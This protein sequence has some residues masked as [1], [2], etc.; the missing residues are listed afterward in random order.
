MSLKVEDIMADN[1]ITIEERGTVREAAEMMSK[2]DIG[3]LI[4]QKKGNP[5]GIITERDMLRRVILDVVD[6]VFTK[7][8]EIMSKPL[9]SGRPGMTIDEASNLMRE[10]KI[11]KLPIVKNGQ[12]VGLVTTTDFVRSP[13]MIKMMIRRIKRQIYNDVMESIKAKLEQD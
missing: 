2:H 9:V 6:P 3:C 1:V 11:K 7:V 8:H 12:V 10:K 13:Q 4:V 5:V